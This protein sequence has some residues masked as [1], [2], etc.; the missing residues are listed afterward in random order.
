MILVQKYYTR[1]QTPLNLLK[2]QKQ[3]K[4]NDVAQLLGCLPKRHETLFILS[5]DRLESDST[6]LKSNSGEVVARG[7]EAQGYH[8]LHR[9]F[10]RS[11]S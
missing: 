1:K 3:L 7:P 10:E 5:T 4:S 11:V 2:K 9:E 8:Q 6:G